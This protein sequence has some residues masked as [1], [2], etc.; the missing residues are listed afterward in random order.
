MGTFISEKNFHRF[1]KQFIICDV[2][3]FPSFFY[4]LQKNSL[5]F[6]LISIFNGRIYYIV[7]TF[8]LRPFHKSLMQFLCHVRSMN[9]SSYLLKLIL[10]NCFSNA[11]KL[12]TDSV[13]VYISFFDLFNISKFSVNI[14]LRCYLFKNRFQRSQSHFV[15]I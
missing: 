14:F 13:L 12:S 15:K 6:V 8:N 10:S 9:C 1:T 7:L 11:S 2:N 5:F 4:N 3:F